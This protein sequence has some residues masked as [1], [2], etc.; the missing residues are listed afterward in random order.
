MKPAQQLTT[1]KRA[2]EKPGSPDP[3]EIFRQ[4]CRKE[5]MRYTPERGLIID[6]IY[7]RDGHFDVDG[8]FS[9]I[10]NRHPRIKLAKCSI[11]RS[12]PHFIKAGLL[13]ESLTREGVVCYEHTLGHEH[14]DHMRCIGCGKIIEFYEPDIDV[15]RQRFC[16]ESKFK[17]IQHTHVI[18]G[19]CSQC[20]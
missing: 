19:Y 8:L 14:H 2:P 3:K 12:L 13:R 18:E 1:K 9:R 5:A 7:R 20:Q 11:Y 4:Y 16:K 10:R 6:E 15:V 17:M